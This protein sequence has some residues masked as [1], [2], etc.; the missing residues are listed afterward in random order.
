MGPGIPADKREIVLGRRVRLDEARKVAGSG[1]GLSLVA[2]VTK[3]HGARL[4][5]D[6]AAPGLR[7]SLNFKDHIHV[8]VGCLCDWRSV[9]TLVVC[10]RESH[11][12][13]GDATPGSPPLSSGVDL[14][15]V[16][17]AVR[18]QD[19]L[20]R[21]LNGKWLDTFQIPADRAVYGAFTV[22]DDKVQDQ[23]KTIVDGLA[24]SAAGG[25]ADARKIADL[26]ASYMDEAKLDA[27]GVK[28]L[29]PEFAAIEALGNKKDIPALIAHLNRTGVGAP[30]D[31]DVELD[32]REST[33]Y[34]VNI[35]QSGLGLPDRDYYLKKDAK[36]VEVREKYLTHIEKLLGLAGDRDSAKNAAAI[37]KLET[38]MAQLQWTKV[39]NRDPV[40]TYNK[41]AIAALG[42]AG[43]RAT[44]GGSICT[45]SASTARSIT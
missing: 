25:D 31:L 16:D 13:A 8:P 18:P 39:Q 12:A 4:I 42:H 21:Y 27:L 43:R 6:D 40:K 34:A 32:A 7:V 22:I 15:Y 10:S 23:L 2:A 29:R 30:Y 5:L 17:H 35:S 1:L 41:T 44:I 20:Y 37:L 36:L 24:K 11:A 38:A 28:P 26:Y 19:D 3:L 9:L 33:R 45:A 14:Q